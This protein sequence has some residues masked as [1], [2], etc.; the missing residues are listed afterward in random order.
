MG[1]GIFY[2]SLPVLPAS[3]DN[4][5]TP[6][7]GSGYITVTSNTITRFNVNYIIDQ[8]TR[9][10]YVALVDTNFAVTD[11]HPYSLQN[12]YT[13]RF[14][15][16]ICYEALN[17]P[18][19]LP[20]GSPSG[21]TQD[22]SGNVFLNNNAQWLNATNIVWQP[23]QSII[24]A[25]P[26]PIL[27]L[28][29]I[30]TGKYISTGKTVN[31][32]GTFKPSTT[33]DA[34][35]G[36]YY[37][38]LPLQ[39]EYN[40][41]NTDYAVGN[42]FIY[43]TSTSM[44]FSFSCTI[45]GS[46]TNKFY[47]CGGNT[48]Q[49]YF[50]ATFPLVHLNSGSL[51]SWNITYESITSPYNFASGLDVPLRY[52]PVTRNIGININSPKY[53]L[54]ISGNL[55]FTGKLLNNGMVC[56][57]IMQIGWIPYNIMW[58][59]G[60]TV[61]ST[62][63]GTSIIG[64]Y[65]QTGSIVTTKIQL[66]ITSS[67]A[68]LPNQSYWEF[69]LPI[70]PSSNETGSLGSY[71]GTGTILRASTR[72]VIPV[73]VTLINNNVHLWLG[74]NDVTA[75]SPFIWQIGD[76]LRLHFEYE[77][78]S[79]GVSLPSS[80]S[81]LIQD[82]SGNI[83]LNNEL[84]YI[85]TNS[86]QWASYIPSII[87]DI[88]NSTI[89]ISSGKLYNMRYIQFGNFV[90]CEFTL[91]FT[92]SN[93]GLGKFLIS[94]PIIPG[95]TSNID[96]P[97]I[98][99]G[100][101]LISDIRYNIDYIIDISTN[102]LYIV[103]NESYN[104]I[105]VSNPLLLQNNTV[106]TLKGSITYEALYSP[107]VLP[108]SSTNS[109]TQDT[110]GNIYLNKN[111]QWLNATNILWQTYTT[112]IEA[113][114]SPIL[115]N[116]SITS[117]YISIGK[118]ISYQGSLTIGST[119][120][121]GSG[122]YYFSLPIQAQHNDNNTDYAIGNAFIYDSSLNMT[123]SYTCT[124]LGTNT[125]V[126]YLC[127]GLTTNGVLSSTYNFN[128][129]M[130]I[131]W[132]IN[133]ESTSLPYNIATG[134]QAPIRYDPSTNYIGVGKNNPNYSF[135][136]SGNINFTG[137]LYNNGIVYPTLNQLIWTPYTVTWYTGTYPVS[138]YN[139]A[140]LTGKYYQTGTIVT[141]KI[142]LLMTSLPTLPNLQ[143]WEFTVPIT[144]SSNENGIIGTYV[145]TGSIIRTTTSL[146]IPLN[147]TLNNGQIHLWLGTN[148][149]TGKT[150]FIWQIGDEV[151]IQYQYEANSIGTSLPLNNAPITQDLSGNIYLNNSL[152]FI[153]TNQLEWSSYIPTITTDISNT[154]LTTNTGTL[155]NMRYIQ[156]GKLIN[157]EFTLQFII[158]T[159]GTG[160]FL[161]SLPIIPGSA[162]NIDTPIVGTGSL[163]IN[164][165]RYNINFSIDQTT[166]LL[167]IVSNDSY[168]TF[169]TIYPTDIQNGTLVK[170]NGSITYES[171]LAPISLP[172]V[173]V[174]ALTQDISGNVYLNNNQQYI[175]ASTTL[176]NTY[177]PSL[178]ATSNPI[179]GSGKYC[180]LGQTINCQGSF[181]PS[182]KFGSGSGTYYITLPI[183]AYSITSDTVIGNAIIYDISNN[184]TITYTC[185]L[186]ASNTN[187]FYLSNNNGPF[188]S[189]YSCGTLISWSLTYETS[190]IPYN[191]PSNYT[192]IYF[193]P[194]NQNIGIGKTIPSSTLDISGTC[195]SLLFNGPS[196]NI[197]NI[198][199]TSIQTSTGYKVNGT[200]I[201]DGSNNIIAN[202][203]KA[204]SG[205]LIID[206]SNNI[207]L[208]SLLYVNTS[209][210]NIGI[211]TTNPQTAL[212]VT[213]DVRIDGHLIITGTTTTI[214]TD[215]QVTE[216]LIITNNGTGPALI[217]NQTGTNPIIEFQDDG[218]TVMKIING[219]NVGI[220][221][222][223][224]THTLDVSG[225]VNANTY[226]GSGIGLT[227]I[228][229]SNVSSGTLTVTN[230]GI[231][232]T[233]INNTSLLVG[234]GSNS[235]IT[236]GN[237]TWN[238]T[239]NTLSATNIIGNLPATTVTAGTYGSSTN[240]ASITV[241]SDGRITS[242]AN[243]AINASQWITNASNISYTKTVSIGKSTI[244]A[245]YALDVSGNVDI[246]GNVS[247]I[248]I[249]GNM[250]AS[251]I[252]SGTL[253]VAN[254]GT[255]LTTLATNSLLIG[256]GTNT[257][258]QPSNL[259]WDNANSRLGINKI[260]PNYTLDVSGNVNFSGNIYQNGTIF[261][262]NTSQWTTNSTNI[263]YSTG[264]VGIGISTPTSYALQVVGSIGATG[265]VTANYSDSRLKTVINKLDNALNKINKLNAFTYTNNDLAKSFGFTDDII[266]VGLSAQEVQEVLPEAV[267]PA[268]FDIETQDDKIISK[269]GKNYITVQYEKLVPLLIAALQE[270]TKLRLVLEDKLNKLEYKV[271][272]QQHCS[273]Q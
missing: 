19:Q 238:N 11:N 233:S 210:G 255:G 107:I 270:E 111:A 65:Y 55:N 242:A 253:L 224:P 67:L 241:G 33:F 123:Y 205:A 232:V 103:S 14:S 201:I 86:I 93:I 272:N 223:N 85:P 70:Y 165:G 226:T 87:T 75:I 2:I 264:N 273:I 128:T 149:V 40:S 92:I 127:G 212:H 140:T 1:T 194:I 254:G 63:N 245:G 158:N 30:I 53:A 166:R 79:I 269:S 192:S 184:T 180:Y 52:D 244:L 160:K 235:I 258:I 177:I 112:L 84:Q 9:Y 31:Y 229:V 202:S 26:S 10:L 170:F 259:V 94:L 161:I 191:V 200:T 189:I 57:T 32:Q 12:N 132:N 155:Y 100:S 185:I 237:L 49:G 27:G 124:V 121:N 39:A 266:R 64:K 5:D 46:N 29:S 8:T 222:T 196:A 154:V 16:S 204:T 136:I 101:I 45:L 38:S 130:L 164:S 203:I 98:G 178:I 247:A 250:N 133:Y 97:I 239:T 137:L 110:S 182:T 18:I 42:A 109:L 162:D 25:S 231:G 173:G 228:N 188:T 48:T 96:T 246:S 43:D 99:T 78:G 15:G 122:T 145:G 4:I 47:L 257:I 268:P 68:T 207:N 141:A 218:N 116:S 221:T 89:S 28:D 82:L 139:G 73:N 236:S 71:V 3:A 37:F 169:T 20:Y 104:A 217:V 252:N 248:N 171:L 117:K 187:L 134:Y 260:G 83:Y 66:I 152:Q 211:G 62:L 69:S 225:N 208:S 181:I 6:I 216:Q 156:L 267:R 168:S 24:S 105:T 163:T 88:S 108:T 34:G 144:P 102:L 198:N 74:M 151:R 147:I 80:L 174:N 230:G 143:Y 95:S 21:L 50:G 129:N 51:I 175:N 186:L 251:N 142:Q 150:P 227:N 146:V 119:F 190:S 35:N 172:H 159:I 261:Q 77:A 209:S 91:K 81:T 118:T 220:G 90:T 138:L 263:Y 135:D 13:V 271:A 265:D 41:A 17:S 113:I 215:S 195:T 219:G 22:L 125:N 193:N 60:T 56:P 131:S 199:A 197:T 179:Y 213:Q 106:I 36:I 114:E 23:Y 262:S 240:V 58:Y 44:V 183:Q 120:I 115:N 54:D 256:N 126:F 176:W 61:V 59:T 72:D 206:T 148:D 76:E 234:N 157:C 7:V 153:P 167:Y 249:I 243:V 214:N